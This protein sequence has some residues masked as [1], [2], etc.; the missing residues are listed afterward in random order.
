MSA[1]GY[2]SPVQN[3][4]GISSSGDLRTIRCTTGPGGQNYRKKFWEAYVSNCNSVFLDVSFLSSQSEKITHARARQ[5][6]AI[7]SEA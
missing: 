6:P 3:R 7:T 4:T 2:C 1:A 5:N